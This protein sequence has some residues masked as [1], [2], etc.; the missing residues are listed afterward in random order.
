[1]ANIEKDTNQ[2][3]RKKYF[4]D[5]DQILKL[6]KRSRK[7]TVAT[8]RIIPSASIKVK[9]STH[10][11]RPGSKP[12]DDIINV[13]VIRDNDVVKSIQIKCPCGRHAELDCEYSPEI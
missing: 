2:A 8:S 6:H 9:G 1:M 13:Q 7:N 5:S 4:A 3:L 12:E 11:R 10:L